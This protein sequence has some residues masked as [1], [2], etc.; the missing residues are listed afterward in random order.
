[1]D[2]N[3]SNGEQMQVHT[4]G[5]KHNSLETAFKVNIDTRKMPKD[6]Y[7]WRIT[8]KKYWIETK[9]G[10]GKTSGMMRVCYSSFDCLRRRWSMP[11]REKYYEFVCLAYSFGQLKRLYV[12]RNTDVSYLHRY[13]EDYIFDKKQLERIDYLISKRE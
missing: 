2:T 4:L 10:K 13:K 3:M 7:T 11:Q 1:M 9:E 12:N 8:A 5:D 6:S